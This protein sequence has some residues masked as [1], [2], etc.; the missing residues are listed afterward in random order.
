MVVLRLEERAGQHKIENDEIG[1]KIEFTDLDENVLN[2]THNGIRLILAP[3]SARAKQLSNSEKSQGIR[4]SP[5]SPSFFGSFFRTTAEQFLFRDVL[6]NSMSLYLLFKSFLNIGANFNM[7][8]RALAK[9][10]SKC[11]SQKISIN[12]A[13]RISVLLWTVLIDSFLVWLTVLILV[14]IIALETVLVVVLLSRLIKSW[15]THLVRNILLTVL[16]LIE[17]IAL[18]TVLVVVLLSRLIKSWWTHLQSAEDRKNLSEKKKEEEHLRLLSHR[19]DRGGS[20]SSQIRATPSNEKGNSNN[21][22]VVLGTSGCLN[23]DVTLLK[24]RRWLCGSCLPPQFPLNYESEPGYTEKYNSYP[25]DS[26]SFPQ[27]YPCCTRCGGPHETCQCDQ[28][29]FNEP[30]C[31]HC[32]GPHMNFQCQPTNQNSYNS[33]SSG[34]DQPQP[35]QSPDIRQPPQEISIQEMEDLKQQYLDEMKRLINFEYCDE[36]KIAELKENFNDMSIEINKKEKLQQL[37]QWATLST[38]PSK[39]FNSFC[40][41]DDDDEDYTFEITPN[42]PVN[43][44]SMGDEHPNTVPAT[45][46]DEFIESSVENLVLIPSESEGESE[47][48]VPTCEEFTTFSNILFD[49]EYESDSSDDQ[50][51]SDEDVPEKIFSNPMFDEEIIPMKIDQ[52]P[53]N[54]E[55]D[56]IESLRIDETDCDFEEDIRLIKKLLY[57]NYSP[58]PSKE[59]VSANSNTETE[60]FSPSPI[61]VEDS[62]SL[63][64]EIDLSFT[65]DYPMPLG[66]EED[67]YDSESDILILKDLPSN[68][69][70]SLLEIESFHFDIPSFSRRPAKPPDG[71]TGILNIKMMG[72]ISDQKVPM[73]KLMITLVPNQEKSPDLLSHRGLKTFQPSAKF[74]MMIHGKNIPILDVPLFHFYPP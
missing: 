22:T 2:N 71:N 33:N 6:V 72:D 15:W 16:I 30:Y 26:L 37:E 60:S 4:N 73:H 44:L 68:D 50:S 1:W 55:S 57:D 46:L 61:P 35:P 25:Y 14:E 47:C 66:I 7:C 70:L 27:Q 53:H 8:I 41:D 24:I 56:L 42:K 59:F 69:T 74:L 52:H 62:D 9:L 49:V 43:S 38:Y 29:I 58:R 34:F 12:L 63:M 65:L 31:K 48:D 23:V 21:L 5:G 40:Y 13:A 3:K 20:L 17:I 19:I 64:E 45:E 36:I 39:C 18:E 11:K 67:D 32:G 54:A 28:L 51:F 10:S